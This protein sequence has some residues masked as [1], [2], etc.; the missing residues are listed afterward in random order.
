MADETPKSKKGGMPTWGWIA[1]IVALSVTGFLVGM[2]SCAKQYTE[3]TGTDPISR[4]TGMKYYSKKVA[5]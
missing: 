5:A 1:I 3:V 4:A 2:K